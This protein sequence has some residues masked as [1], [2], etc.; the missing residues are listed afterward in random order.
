MKLRLTIFLLIVLSCSHRTTTFTVIENDKL[1]GDISDGLPDKYSPVT[2]KNTNGQIFAEGQCAQYDD[3]VTNIKV[4]NW[5]EYYE[6]G[7]IRNEGQ[8]KIGT[9]IDCCVGGY[10]RAFYFY[11]TGLWKYFD[12]K[13]TLE[14]ELEYK[15]ERLKV[16]TRCGGDTLTYGLIKLIP[17]K[18]WDKLTTD[19]I[20]E[21]QKI[22]FK[23]SDS[24]GTTTY[25]PLNGQLFMDY[26]R[27]N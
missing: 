27:D 10:C 25:T 17:I 23:D 11:R 26:S 9:Y 13:G 1:F 21:L 22:S 14:Y 4:G 5:K 15:S 6:N 7:T 24:N 20:Y 19:K 12:S 3:R 2:L 16:D 18:Y 8:Y